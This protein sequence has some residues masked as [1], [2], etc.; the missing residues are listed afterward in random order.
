MRPLDETPIFAVLRAAGY[1]AAIFAVGVWFFEAD[2]RRDQRLANAWL[3]VN[4]AAGESGDGGRTFA[5]NL[6]NDAGQSLAGAP[7]SR[8]SLREVSLRGAILTRADMSGADLTGADLSN[9]ALIRADLTCAKFYR[10]NLRGADLSEVI[11]DEPTARCQP[12]VERTDFVRADLTG[13]I[14]FQLPQ[15]QIADLC[16]TFLPDGEL[17][18]R[19]C[20]RSD[21]LS[22]S[23][24][25]ARRDQVGR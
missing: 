19:D 23:E 14:N 24:C 17:S 3:L 25:E 6:L 1:I 12:G 13:A 5:L 20:A 22:T 8:A 11:Y 9:A 4:A 2:E 21:T 16:F 15:E 10:A 7:L 18:C